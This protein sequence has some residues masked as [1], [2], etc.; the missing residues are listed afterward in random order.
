MNRQIRPPRMNDGR[1]I[2]CIEKIKK[3][4]KIKDELIILP[5]PILPF[6]VFVFVFA[7][8]LSLSSLFFLSLLSSLSFFSLLSSL[9]SLLS[10]IFSLLSSLFYLLFSVSQCLYTVYVSLCLR[11]LEHY[12]FEKFGKN[13]SLGFADFQLQLR[14]VECDR[15]SFMHG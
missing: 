6:P 9:F 10:S 12:S 15:C 7:L 4:K 11:L 1:R 2:Y 8:S 5:L 13:L 3:V 14:S